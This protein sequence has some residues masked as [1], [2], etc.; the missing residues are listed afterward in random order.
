M[1]P[2]TDASARLLPSP[3][4]GVCRLDERTGWCVGCGRGGEELFG[5]GELPVERQ[6]EIWARL[7][8]RMAEL[9]RPVRVAPWSATALMA[10]LRALTAEP[11]T[12]WSFGG[13]G[14][15]AEFMASP[16][17]PITVE[18]AGAGLLARHPDGAIAFTP[19]AGVRGFV[20]ESE[21]AGRELIL[22]RYRAGRRRPP[23]SVGVE[24]GA[25][26]AALDPAARW[27]VRFDLGLG[28]P[29]YRF[30]VR[31]ADDGLLATLRAAAG[32]PFTQRLDL[33]RALVAASPARVV[34]TSAGRC[35]VE[36]PIPRAGETTPE[37]PHTHLLPDRLVPPRRFE[38]ELGLPEGYLVEARVF[39]RAEAW[40]AA[41]L[42]LDAE[43]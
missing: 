19:K 26:E 40:Q 20:R 11:G 41:G 39:A 27:H 21:E 14:A 17:A 5:W 9:R 37:G 31:T 22:A 36:A 29:A 2:A 16:S 10:K 8:A 3:C 12:V 1:T 34:A 32:A 38:A 18:A 25:D 30:C 7:P 13:P 35:E 28:Q 42:D 23:A 6:R 4:V 33:A 43:A 15:S 24:L